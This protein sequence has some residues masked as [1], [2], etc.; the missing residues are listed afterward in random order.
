MIRNAS[1]KNASRLPAAWRTT[2]L[3][4]ARVSGLQLERELSSHFGER[5]EAIHYAPLDVAAL[6]N[7]LPNKYSIPL[8][9]LLVVMYHNQLQQ[10]LQEMN[11][12]EPDA[13]RQKGVLE[14]M[15]E[16]LQQ[17]SNATPVWKDF[18]SGLA[19]QLLANAVEAVRSNG[20]ELDPIRACLRVMQAYAYSC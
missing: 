11:K 17:Y 16:P 2:Q 20:T 7:G 6:S 3:A 12:A 13:M 14:R 10:L 8:R 9:R 1:D 15:I 5:T 18:R 4:L 19:D